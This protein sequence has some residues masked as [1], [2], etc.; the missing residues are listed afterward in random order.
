VLP[1]AFVTV[2]CA[3][4]HKLP[5]HRVPGRKVALASGTSW[6][7]TVPGIT[8]IHASITTQIGPP[9]EHV[10]QAL[11]HVLQALERICNDAGFATRRKRVLTSEGG[12]RADLLSPYT[13]LLFFCGTY[14]IFESNLSYQI[15]QI[16]QIYPWL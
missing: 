5:G 16:Y 6:V 12:R 1:T 8:S 10:L 7:V 11:E 13:R 4:Q 14:K 2:F 3:G 15:T 9:R